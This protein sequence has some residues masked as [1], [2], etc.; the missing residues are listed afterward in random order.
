MKR[1]LRDE[2]CK[3]LRSGKWIQTQEA[4]HRE[5]KGEH[6]YCCLGVFC[7]VMGEKW[8]VS[9]IDSEFEEKLYAI[10]YNEDASLPYTTVLTEDLNNLING[11]YGHYTSE[12]IKMN[13]NGSTFAEIADWIEEN[14]P[15]DPE[16][17]GVEAC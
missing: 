12:L 3:R 2:W 8:N 1:K 10:R 13:D 5:Y 11:D 7:D 17:K 16:L 4:L 14:I 6:S 15:V 9:A